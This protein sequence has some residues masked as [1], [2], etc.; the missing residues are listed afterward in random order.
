MKLEDYL[1]SDEIDEILEKFQEGV[2]QRVQRYPAFEEAVSDLDLDDVYF[3]VRSN[4]EGNRIEAVLTI[5][6]EDGDS[7]LDEDQVE[8]ITDLLSEVF[9]EAS[10]DYFQEGHLSKFA[11]LCGVGDISET[12]EYY[13]NIDGK[14]KQ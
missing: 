9:P 6:T 5:D 4:G 10:N 14:L 8:A 2:A 1:S 7:S 3:T 11:E 13:V 12:L